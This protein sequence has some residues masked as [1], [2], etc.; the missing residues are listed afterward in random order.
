MAFEVR[1]GL[2][3]IAVDHDAIADGLIVIPRQSVGTA[4][5]APDR[6]P[7]ARRRMS[8]CACGSSGCRRSSAMVAGVP[9]IDPSSGAAV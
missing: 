3:G 5:D 2:D 8:R 4:A 6:V 9:A 1:E 7:P